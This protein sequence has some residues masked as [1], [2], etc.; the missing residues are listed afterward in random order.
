MVAR[1]EYDLKERVRDDIT[2]FRF[3]C[4]MRKPMD[5]MLQMDKILTNMEYAVSKGHYSN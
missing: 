2:R 4:P 1:I 5:K 3:D